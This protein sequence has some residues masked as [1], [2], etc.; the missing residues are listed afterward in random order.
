MCWVLVVGAWLVP[1]I[2][3]AQ[4]PDRVPVLD[5]NAT[6]FPDGSLADCRDL[7]DA[8]AGRRG[9]VF[10]GSDGHLYFEDGTRARF[11]GVNVAKDAVFQPREIIDQAADAIARAG[12]N[13]VRLHHLDDETGL[14]PGAL[15]GSA[16][17]VDAERLAA[18]DYWIAALKRRGIYVYLDLLDYRTFREAEGVPSG[19]QLGRGAKPYALFSARL[20]ELQREFAGRFLFDHV[21][22]HTGLSYAA[23]PAVCVV[24]LCDENGLFH[25]W[26]RLPDLKSPYREEL[27]RQWNLWLL[28]R[29]GS[30]EIL[31]RTWTD[32]RGR[33]GLRASEDPARNTV[34]LPG[35]SADAD[36]S[37]P[38]LA[39]RA[40]FFAD[41]HREYFRGMIHYLRSRGLRCPVTAVTAPQVLPD[42]WASAQELDCIATNYYYDH[43]YYRRGQEWQLPAFFSGSN[44]LGDRSQ[45]SFP[46][47]VAAAR[48]VGK[49]VIVREWGTCWPNDSRGA[50]MLEAAAYGCLQDVD[51]M[52][53]FAL[54]TRPGQRKME[55]FDVRHDPVRWGLVP[56]CSRMFLRQQVAVAGHSVAVAHSTTDVFLPGADPLPTELY[57]LSRVV[58][59]G[60]LFSGGVTGTE[61]DLIVAAGRG[62]AT[63]F[64][65]GPAII[66]SDTYAADPYGH[67]GASASELNGYLRPGPVVEDAR[68]KF[69]GSMFSAGEERT[70]GYITPLPL[71]QVASRPT[72]RAIGTIGDSGCLGLRDMERKRY[73]FGRLGDELKLRVALDALRQCLGLGVGHEMVDRRAWTSDTGQVMEEQAAGILLINTPCCVAVAGALEPGREVRCGALSLQPNARM[74]ACVWQSLDDRPLAETDRWSLRYVTLAGNSGQQ[75]RP[76]LIKPGMSIYALEADGGAP[77]TTFGRPSDAPLSVALQGRPVLRAFLSN[78]SFELLRSGQQYRLTCDTAGVRLELPALPARTSV[79]LLQAAGGAISE[80]ISGPFIWREGVAVLQTR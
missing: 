41:V 61:A 19:S 39:S 80:E 16:Q 24:E 42:L 75:V 12:F 47:Q 49:P 2:A 46:P 45:G 3:A 8:P 64:E 59:L 13:L 57:D 76:H 6:D 53:L 72:W 36:T 23:D 17:R 74:V 7:L 28:S 20:I 65:G 21:N 60:Q 1:L 37:I 10:A 4:G 52:I 56:A 11:W 40:M 35:V 32:D 44:V 9:F 25:G 66:S 63:R 38:R 69:G 68:V 62:A 34:A 71:A 5:P 33:C 14:L 70:L 73:V 50:G 77:V 67:A 27:V 48:V 79:T 26:E 30:R 55:F 51:M 78:G 58:R 18:V 54:D 15:A 29:Y 43:P 22:P 31:Q